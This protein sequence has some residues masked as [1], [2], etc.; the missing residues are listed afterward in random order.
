M[1]VRA[2]YK[3]PIITPLLQSAVAGGSGVRQ[4]TFAS[5]FVNEP[6]SPNLEPIKCQ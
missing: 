3:W 2:Y 5:V 6:Y 1:L 4:V